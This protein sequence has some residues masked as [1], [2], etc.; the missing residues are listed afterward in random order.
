MAITIHEISHHRTS[1]HSYSPQPFENCRTTQSYAHISPILLKHELFRT[2]PTCHENQE[3]VSHRH[4][5]SRCVPV[6]ELRLNRDLPN[7]KLKSLKS[8]TTQ[9]DICPSQL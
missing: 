7:S 6:Y 3:M 8:Y 2:Q 9:P 1:A 4:S 5:H